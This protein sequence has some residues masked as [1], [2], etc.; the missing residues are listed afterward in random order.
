L[1]IHPLVECIL[2]LIELDYYLGAASRFSNSLVVIVSDNNK[3]EPV[4]S[5]PLGNRFPLILVHGNNNEIKPETKYEWEKFIKRSQYHTANSFYKM[6]L[7]HWDSTKSSYINGVGLGA[8]IETEAE[9]F[10]KSVVIL[11]HSRGGLV[12]RCFMNDY[13]GIQGGYAGKKG[14][15]RVKA[16]VTLATPHRGAPG[17]DPNWTLFALDSYDGH[18]GI[19]SSEVVTLSYFY[20]DHVFDKNSF[21]Y[22]Q[23]DDVDNVIS[24]NTVCFYPAWLKDLE[25]CSILWHNIPEYQEVSNLNKRE[26]YHNKIIAYGGNSVRYPIPVDI[27]NWWTHYKLSVA[28]ALLEP[29][30]IIP[31]GY[32]IDDI[33]DNTLRFKANDGLVPLASA[34]YLKEGSGNLFTPDGKNIQY[35]KDTLNGKCQIRECNVINNRYTDHQ[36]FLDDNEIIDMVIG[37]LMNLILD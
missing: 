29:M 5:Y 9:L 23:W 11:A 34:L 33:Y 15:E 24:N 6:Y 30:P 37:R 28:A 4:D 17:S 25:Y 10:D 19:P 1:P 26:S 35:N 27:E 21:P 2:L 31:N 14:G 20:I 8:S 18:Y 16:L 12:S 7:F 36:H 13:I 32:P 3:L 22:L